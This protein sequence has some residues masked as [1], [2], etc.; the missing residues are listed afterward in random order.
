MCGLGYFRTPEEAFQSYK[1]A[2]EEWIKEVAN[3]WR[4]KLD[5]KVYEALCNY[6]IEIDD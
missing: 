5:V 4:D 2:K 3:K 6:K 1:I